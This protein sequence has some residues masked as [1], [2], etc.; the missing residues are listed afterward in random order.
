MAQ[1]KDERDNPKRKVSK[2]KL[3][4]VDPETGKKIGLLRKMKENKEFNRNEKEK[5]TPKKEVVK[6]PIVFT[7]AMNNRID[8]PSRDNY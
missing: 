8:A 3:I 4:E 6:E 5:R 7:N 1:G 2:I